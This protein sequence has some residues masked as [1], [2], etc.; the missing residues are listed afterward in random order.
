MDLLQTAEALKQDP[1]AR[2][3]AKRVLA[4][5]SAPRRGIGL[6][7]E[8]LPDFLWRP[9]PGTAT[10]RASGRFPHFTELW[11]GNGARPDL[12]ESTDEAWWLGQEAW[13]TGA[14]SP[15]ITNFELAVYPVTGAQCRPFVEQGYRED[16]WWSEA[17][18]VTVVIERSPIFGMTRSGRWIITRWGV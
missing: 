1:P 8:A 12:K 14:K 17:G 10:V 9:I 3:A 18:G 4:N 15:D 16:R 6:G 2:A 11:L 13:P 5:L 7:Q